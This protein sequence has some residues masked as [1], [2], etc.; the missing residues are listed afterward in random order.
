MVKHHCSNFRRITAISSGVLIFGDFT[1][2]Y[3]GDGPTKKAK[4]YPL[5]H[6]VDPKLVSRNGKKA[7]SFVVPLQTPGQGQRIT[8]VRQEFG[9]KGDLFGDR[10]QYFEQATPYGDTL[11]TPAP[12]IG[13]FT[14]FQKYIRLD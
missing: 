10:E 4:V 8:T 9:S 12:L 13:W 11:Y 5:I 3:S 6:K 2:V 1:V 14:D 7:S